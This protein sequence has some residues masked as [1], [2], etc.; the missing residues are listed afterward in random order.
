MKNMINMAIFGVLF[1]LSLASCADDRQAS[2]VP[3][4]LI[5]GLDGALAQ[6]EPGVPCPIIT[7]AY[8]HCLDLIPLD[9]SIPLGVFDANQG[10]VATWITIVIANAPAE[11][12][13]YIKLE[14]ETDDGPLNYKEENG[15]KTL[16][17]PFESLGTEGIRFQD[18]YMVPLDAVCCAEDFEGRTGTLKITVTFTDM[19]PVTSEWPFTLGEAPWPEDDDAILVEACSCSAWPQNVDRDESLC[20]SD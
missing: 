10:G 4:Q 7:Y 9:T 16:R 8:T 14:M 18:Q 11:G 1:A 2:G 3:P 17:V 15:A 5:E 6:C 19:D 20:E 13:P 12:N